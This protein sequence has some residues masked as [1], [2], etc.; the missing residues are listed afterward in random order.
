[1]TS[2]VVNEWSEA[3]GGVFGEAFGDGADD[4]RGASRGGAD[5]FGGII[6]VGDGLGRACGGESGD[7]DGSRPDGAVIGPPP[8]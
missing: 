4:F 7:G 1:M 2:S 5:D 6:G 3:F 8:P